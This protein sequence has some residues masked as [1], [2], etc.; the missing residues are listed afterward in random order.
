MYDSLA[1]WYHL[2]FEN[3][4]E[5][6]ARQAA[7]FGPLIEKACRTRQARVL[8][9]AC[10]IGTQALGLAMRG[11]LVTGSD[12]SE[13]AVSRA[14]VEAE[15]RHITL[16]LYVADMRDLSCVQGDPFDAVLIADNAFAHLPSEADLL[17]TALS[18]ARKLIPGGLFLATLRDYDTLVRE[19]PAFEGP[20]LY[21]DNGRRRIVHQ[22]WDWTGPQT[23][24]MHLYI[25]RQTSGGWQGFHFTSEFNSI[26]R[27]AVQNALVSARFRDVRW[28]EPRESGF[29]QPVV[30]ARLD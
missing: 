18:A 29:Y 17:K 19:R 5:S 4:D 12:L 25:T 14:R 16:P 10:G 23:Y 24:T 15:L 7:V 11:H 1:A 21:N 9:A 3:W 6:I 27:R 13:D 30:M 28:L 20:A 8:D 26:S 2:I 22:L